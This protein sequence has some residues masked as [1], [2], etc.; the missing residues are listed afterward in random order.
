MKKDECNLANNIMN[1]IP[2]TDMSFLVKCL[3]IGVSAALV[4]FAITAAILFFEYVI[5]TNF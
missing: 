5:K 1:K 4:I 2:K 3:S